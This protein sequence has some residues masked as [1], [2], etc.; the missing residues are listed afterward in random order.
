MMPLC[1]ERVRLLVYF[2]KRLLQNT[3]RTFMRTSQGIPLALVL[4]A[5]GA[6]AQAQTNVTGTVRA[7]NGEK[8]QGVTVSIKN[9]QQSVTTGAEGEY[10]IAVPAPNSA[11]VFSYVG[12]TSQEVAVNNRNQVNITLQIAQS[13]LNEVVVVGYGTV[14]RREL[15]SAVTTIRAKDFVPGPVNNP[16]QLIDG[17]AAGVTVS[18][19]AAADPN[20]NPSVQIRGASSIIAGNE[21]LY[22]I[23]GMPGGNI[24]NLAQQDIESM[25]VLKDASAG[26]IYGSRGANGVVLIQTKRGRSGAAT[27]TYDSYIEHDKVSAKPNI[28]SPEE[29]VQR[30][31]DADRGARV[32]RYDELLNKNNFGQNHYLS[33]SG[34]NE[35]TIFRLS[36]NYR[37]KSAIDI[38]SNRKEYGLRA[39]FQQKAMNDLLEISGNLSYRVADEEY[40]NYGAFKQAVKLNPTIP[41]YDPNDPNKYNFLQGYDTYNP[42]QDLKT[43]E[44]GADNT[45]SI[46]DVT[47]KLNLT[48]S[49]NTQLKLATQRTDQ[50]RR[51]Y[52]NTESVESISNNRRGRARLQDSRWTDYTLE[53]TGNYDQDFG[54]HS[55][56]AVGGYSY[57]EFN[58]QNFYAENADFASDAFSYNNLGNGLWNLDEGRLGMGSDRSRE[59]TIAFL[60]RV[61]YGY[62]DTYFL[63]GSLRYEG[64]S[65]FG[66]NNKWGLFPSLSAAWRISN[67]DFMKNSGAVNELKLRFSYG[68]AGRSNFNR[69]TSLSRYSGYGRYQNAEGEWIQVFGPGNNYNPDL[70]WEKAVAYDLGVDFGLFGNR[71]T[72]SLDIFDRRNNDLISNYNVPVGPYP[73]SEMT[74][75]VGSTSAKGVE[76]SVS[77]DAVRSDKFNYTTTVVASYIKAKL[78]SWSNDVYKSQYRYFGDLPS[79]GNPGPAYRLEDGVEI[80]S[81]YGYKYA[82]VDETGQILVWKDGIEGKE[83]IIASSEANADRDRVYLGNGAPRYELAWNNSLSYGPFDLSLYF[84]GRFDYEIINLYQMYF[85]L[86]AEPGVNLLKDAYTRNGHI[87]SGKVIT[88]YFLEKGDYFRL[89]NITLGWTPAFKSERLRS[90]RLYGTVRNVFTVTDYSG[91][92]PMQVGVTGLT[93]GFGSL[94]VYPVTRTFSLGLQ[95]TL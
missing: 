28:L 12:Y 1:F 82:G 60:G 70:K 62:D 29:F 5:T 64:N 36:G 48:K 38:A 88:D 47:A 2:A 26:A 57:Q 55:I 87:T 74:V 4:L 9:S 66:A 84:R 86:Q 65:K 91:L 27:V 81:F 35:K 94:D 10:S 6:L 56:Q 7:A 72:G 43:R 50:L 16:L 77:W 85:G 61:N 46:I 8:L 95:V 19:P 49:L 42:L 13:D 90:L 20:S 30:G 73:L 24:R 3:Q 58:E 92:D 21:P 39:S 44:N 23:D 14:Q 41:I 51:E 71:I 76:L 33:V 79:P 11:L 32:K 83:A 68:A 45:Y 52:Y 18:A 54:N 75:N 31:R 80:G 78:K 15:T 34:G 53:W 22:I 63:T 37:T 67:M 25:T 17:K 69:Y 89:D 93:P 59:K 40:T